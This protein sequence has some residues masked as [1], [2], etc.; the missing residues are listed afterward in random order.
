M[1]GRSSLRGETQNEAGESS[2]KGE[3]QSEGEGQE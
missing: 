1:K 2:L 3:V